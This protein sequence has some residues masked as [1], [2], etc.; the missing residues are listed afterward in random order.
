MIQAVAAHCEDP[1][2]NPPPRELQKAWQAQRWGVLPNDGGLRDQRAG[3]IERM[4]TALNIYEAYSAFLAAD[5]WSEFKKR[6]PQ[7]FRVAMKVRG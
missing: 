1:D 4:T 3:E 7:Q 5:D 2:R 6:H